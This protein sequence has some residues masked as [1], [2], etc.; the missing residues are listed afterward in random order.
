MGAMVE[1]GRFRIPYAEPS[2]KTRAE[3][4]IG[5]LLLYPKGTN[6]LVMALWLAQ[7]PIQHLRNDYKSWFSKGGRGR[8]YHVPT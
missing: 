7:R 2:D 1:N 6:D 5:D 8:Y 4:F 3:T